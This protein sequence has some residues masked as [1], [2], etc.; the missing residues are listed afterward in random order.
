MKPA[1]YNEKSGLG[2]SDMGLDHATGSAKGDMAAAKRV[3]DLG[4]K[5]DAASGHGIETPKP[6]SVTYPGTMGKK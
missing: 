6:A 2:M 5:P 4:G 3:A 1:T